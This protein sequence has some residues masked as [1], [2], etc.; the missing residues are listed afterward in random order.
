MA[1]EL[2]CHVIE[3]I[4]QAGS[5][6]PGG[7]LSSA[8]IVALLYGHVLEIRPDD[9]HWSNRDRFVLA[10]G[11]AAPLLYAALAMRDFFE[12]S[13]LSSLRK[14]GSRLQGH[15]DCKS[16]PGVE[17]STGSL[18]QGLSIGVGMALAGQMDDGE[19]G[20][21]VLL[22]DGELQEGQVWEAAMAAAHYKLANLVAIIDYNGL[23]I[24]GPI[25]EVLS[26]EPLDDKWRAFGWYVQEVDGHDFCQLDQAIRNAQSASLPAVI[27]A[28]TI[29]GKGVDFM[30][31]EC[32]WHGKAPSMEQC[33]DALQQIRGQKG[34]L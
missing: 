29:K 26:P 5:G 27:I 6:H 19:W 20:V 8:D 11:H 2:R 17:A 24:D 33:H 31:G 18:G 16:T 9:T 32:D 14:L 3:S 21:Y 28:H 34:A 13:E 10:K 12:P 7:S 25:R 23:Q 1:D 22:G 30:E 15:P 4:A